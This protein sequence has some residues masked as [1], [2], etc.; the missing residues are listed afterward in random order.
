MAIDKH[1]HRGV[2]LIAEAFFDTVAKG[3]ESRRKAKACY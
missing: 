2:A 1:C 3:D